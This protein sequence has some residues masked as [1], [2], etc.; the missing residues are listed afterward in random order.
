MRSKAMVA[1]LDRI[2][3]ISSQPSSMSRRGLP[4]STQ[5]AT[6]GQSLILFGWSISCLHERALEAETGLK[7]A[8]WH[9]PLDALLEDLALHFS[10]TVYHETSTCRIGDVVDSRLRVMGV[11]I[12]RVA[13]ASIMPNVI[14]G[15][16][17]A[18]TIMIG[19]RLAEFVHR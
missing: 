5:V 2:E 17:N 13:D 10:L 16:T 4:R 8:R 9:A 3:R 12:L 19:E 6:L 15:N 1:L 18:P 7:S 14:S 11:L